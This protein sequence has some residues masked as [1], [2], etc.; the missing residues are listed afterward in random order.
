[1]TE[2]RAEASVPQDSRRFATWVYGSL[3]AFVVVLT[4]SYFL[5]GPVMEVME[6]VIRKLFL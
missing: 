6:K 4:L 2:S 3:A 5:A 1:M